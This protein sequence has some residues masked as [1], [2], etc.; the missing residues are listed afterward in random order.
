MFKPNFKNNEPVML[1]HNFLL[2]INSNKSWFKEEVEEAKNNLIN[3]LTNMFGSFSEFIDIF[4]SV[5]YGGSR[6][7]K[8]RL[9]VDFET[10]ATNVNVTPRI[11]LGPRLH[12]LHAHSIISWA[13]PDKYFFQ[14]NSKRLRDY[15]D[16]N[17]PG[18]HVDIKWI[19]G[20]SDINHVLTYINKN[21]G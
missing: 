9:D 4:L 12:R 7:N 3:D 21:Q 8:Q 16:E 18:Y 19:K 15:I 14:I 13:A 11:E 2:T 17:M 20:S 10:I 6:Y 1:V 5:K